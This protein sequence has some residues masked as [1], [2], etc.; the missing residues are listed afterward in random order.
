LCYLIPRKER[1]AQ[2]KMRFDG[3]LDLVKGKAELP[4]RAR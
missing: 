2:G 1:L 4:P 3:L